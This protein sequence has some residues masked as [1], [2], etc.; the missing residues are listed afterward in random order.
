MV[1][2]GFD[3]GSRPEQYKG[4]K[5]DDRVGYFQQREHE[6]REKYVKMA[7][8]KIIR[9]RLKECYLKEEVNQMKNCKELALKYLEAIK[10]TGVYR[11]NS[12]KYE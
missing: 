9:Q 11:A 8:V 12:G 2:K 7:E 10:Y 5:E 3:F 4:S 1:W 6:V